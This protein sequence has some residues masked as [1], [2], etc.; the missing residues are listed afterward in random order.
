V[1]LTRREQEVMALLA[2]GLTNRQIAEALVIGERTAET[3]VANLLK[4]LGVSSRAQLTA[5]AIDHGLRKG[6]QQLDA[7]GRRLVAG[8]LATGDER[9][10]SKGRSAAKRSREKDPY[11]AS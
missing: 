11:P 10:G 2:D 7:S 6:A 3:H 4:K 9:A 1:T 8:P 5:W